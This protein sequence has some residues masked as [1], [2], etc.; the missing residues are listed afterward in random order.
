MKSH[1]RLLNWRRQA[2]QQ[3][4]ITASVRSPARELLNFLKAETGNVDLRN[5]AARPL[6]EVTKELRRLGV[7]YRTGVA[8]ILSLVDGLHE[9][10]TE[11]QASSHKGGA[12]GR[13]PCHSGQP[14]L[15]VVSSTKR[16]RKKIALV[17][18]L[19]TAA[20]LLVGV[21][22]CPLYTISSQRD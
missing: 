17:T 8:D 16:S 7:N 11:V 15:L 20:V 2:G 22:A 18:I 4:V 3:K 13:P 5:I 6:A 12:E 9:G 14:E 1:W 10:N 21:N 19:A